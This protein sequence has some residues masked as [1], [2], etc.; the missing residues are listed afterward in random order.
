MG[1]TRKEV[2]A[3]VEDPRNWYEVSGNRFVQ[4]AILNYKDLHV[5]QIQYRHDL[6]HW[7][8]T[9]KQDDYEPRLVW[10]GGTFWHYDPDTGALFYSISRTHLENK[11]YEME[12]ANEI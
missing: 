8:Y 10:Q 6:N 3:F 5:I 9:T 1:M 4:T 11:I 2:K 7:R 12:H